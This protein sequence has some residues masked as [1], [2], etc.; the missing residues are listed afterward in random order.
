M[1]GWNLSVLE[2][3]EQLDWGIFYID[4]SFPLEVPFKIAKVILKVKF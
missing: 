1:D 2:Y 4:I 3:V